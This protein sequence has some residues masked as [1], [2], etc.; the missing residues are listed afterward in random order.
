LATSRLFSPV[1][2]KKDSAAKLR[3]ESWKKP[4]PAEIIVLNH[5]S[6]LRLKAALNPV[7]EAENFDFLKNS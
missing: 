6:E 3:P 4:I 5:L 2:L 1:P 7:P